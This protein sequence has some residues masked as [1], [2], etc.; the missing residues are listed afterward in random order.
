MNS[1]PESTEGGTDTRAPARDRVEVRVD[2][3]LRQ[4]L[5][6]PNA[7]AMEKYMALTLGRQSV[8]GLMLFELR[9]LLL[10]NL[11]GALGIALRKIFYKRMLGRMGRGVVIGRGVTIRHPHRIRLGDGAIVDDYVVLDGKGDREVTI[12][13]GANCIIGRNVVLSCKQVA[14]TSGRIVLKDQVN[15]SVNCTLISESEL[16]VGEKALIA[17]HCYLN[18][19]GNHG[20]DRLD[21]PILDQPMV[22][23]GGISVAPGAWLGA[24]SVLLDG[25]EV[26]ENAVVAAGAVV[27][28]K[29]DAFTIAGGVPAKL[30]RDRR[31]AP[32]EQE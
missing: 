14:E 3:E 12:D 2:S 18:A 23:R 16:V 24:S 28:G 32:G 17:G 21:L 11:P 8:W 31:Q 19:G 26:G 25:A 27:T 22:H 9:M 7:S 5:K 15:I 29:V 6:D 20:L 30:L 10:C 4:M 1:S 13:V